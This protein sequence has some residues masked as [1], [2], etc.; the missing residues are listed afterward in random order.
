MTKCS[1]ENCR[2]ENCRL[3]NA[4]IPN[5]KLRNVDFIDCEL[6]HVDFS[7]SRFGNG[8]SAGAMR[9]PVIFEN[10]KL[11]GAD[12]ST[13]FQEATYFIKECELSGASFRHSSLQFCTFDQCVLDGTSFLCAQMLSPHFIETPM[14]GID[15]ARSVVTESFAEPMDTDGWEFRETKAANA[16]FHMPLMD[17]VYI[18]DS[19][20]DG[21]GV[22]DEFVMQNCTVADSSFYGSGMLQGRIIGTKFMGSIYGDSKDLSGIEDRLSFER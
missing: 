3:F 12:F 13:T 8:E 4:S 2:F 5:G 19:V 1:F 17:G 20:M 14:K 6:S 7:G 9:M 22:P 10:C 15:M 11:S 21:T 18:K 16:E